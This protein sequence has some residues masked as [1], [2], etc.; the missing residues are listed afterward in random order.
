MEKEP[1]YSTTGRQKYKTMTPAAGAANRANAKKGGRPVGAMNPERLYFMER[2]ARHDER[3]IEIL[4]DIAQND[5]NPGYRLTAIKDLWG[6]AHGRSSQAI[7]GVGKDGAVLLQVR[8]REYRSLDGCDEL[9]DPAV[10]PWGKGGIVEHDE[11][12][13]P[14]P[15]PRPLPSSPRGTSVSCPD[16]L[17]S[18]P[19]EMT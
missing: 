16:T 6:Y 9:P 15:E 4:E 3:H 12:V 10:G 11:T 5:P 1:T 17:P 2:C 18:L 13:K 14:K 19:Q 8:S 7:E